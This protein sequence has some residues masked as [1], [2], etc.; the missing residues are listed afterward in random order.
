[1][2]LFERAIVAHWLAVS[3]QK[4]RVVFKKSDELVEWVMRER[5]AATAERNKQP[6]P[7]RIE[8]HPASQLAWET[9]KLLLL[10]NPK[11]R[12]YPFHTWPAEDRKPLMQVTAELCDVMRSHGVL[13]PPSV[14]N[15]GQK[16]P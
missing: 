9:Q 4:H 15:A 10:F 1:M 11:L 8:K 7:N 3:V 16:Q 6:R 5:H 12:Q 14:R 2:E 13:L